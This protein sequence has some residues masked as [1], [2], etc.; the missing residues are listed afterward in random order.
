MSFNSKKRLPSA[1]PLLDLTSRLYQRPLL[2]RTFVICSRLLQRT[3]K[4]INKINFLSEMNIRKFLTFAANGMVLIVWWKTYKCL[5]LG[6]ELIPSSSKGANLKD[7]LSPPHG[8]QASLAGRL[9]LL[10]KVKSTAAYSRYLHNYKPSIPCPFLTQN[11]EFK[12]LQ[13]VRSL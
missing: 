12:V 13:C 6:E 7:L 3:T 11:F 1:I 5:H 10:T 8:R 9:V 2:P 4:I